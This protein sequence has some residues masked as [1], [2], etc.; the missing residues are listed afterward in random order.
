MSHGGHA[1]H[2][3]PVSAMEPGA[4]RRIA[5]AFA[6]GLLFAAGLALSGM[7]QPGKVIG[8]LDVLGDQGGWDPFGEPVAGQQLRRHER[9]RVLSRVFQVSRTPT[10][11]FAILSDDDLEINP[12]PSMTVRGRVHSNADLDM[13]CGGTLR[14]DTNYLRAMGGIYRRRKNN[15]NSTGTVRVRRWVEDPFDPSEPVNWV[16]MDSRSQLGG[17]AG[18]ISGYDSAFTLGYDANGDGDFTDSGELLPFHAGVGQVGCAQGYAVPDS[19]DFAHT[20]GYGD[21]HPENVSSVVAEPRP[22]AL[23]D[24]DPS[25]GGA[26]RWIP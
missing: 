13:S 8:F 9:R 25:V 20:V 22:S 12:G 1:S 7:T 10:T 15:T 2:G 11:Q 17:I 23:F 5:V 26:P 4:G 6:A 19:Q 14:L 18:N 3:G 24:A 21:A 16:R